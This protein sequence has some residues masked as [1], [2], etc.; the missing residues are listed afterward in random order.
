M[1]N[2]QALNRLIEYA[3]CVG[4][5]TD[6]SLSAERFIV[7][8]CDL[9]DGT[10]TIDFGEND[11]KKNIADIFGMM[12][13]DIAKLKAHMLD[14]INAENEVSFSDTVYAQKKLL[15]AK[16]Q[17]R[18]DKCTVLMPEVLLKCMLTDPSDAIK[19][20]LISDD[21]AIG[22]GLLDKKRSLQ[23][24]LDRLYG[25]LP[26]D[27]GSN[28]PDK[29][30]KPEKPLMEDVTE[31]DR[32]KTVAE[33]VKNVK[34]A[35]ECLLSEI[36]GQD[37]AV[38][39]F[40]TGYFQAELLSLTDKKRVR[41]R[42]MFLF[43]GPPG[44]GKTF[45]AEKAAEVLGL[46]FMRFDMSEY[47][48]HEANIE[49][50]GSDK[51]YKNGKE[52]NVT[53]FVEKNPKCILLFDEIEKA[54]ICVIHLFL[55][56]LDAGRLRDNFTDTE[57]SFTDAII[58]FTTNAGKQLYEQ[59]ESGDFS[60][61][62]KKVILKA[63]KSDVNPET[64]NPFFPAAICSRFA[65]GNVVMFN[66]I[67]AHNLREIAKRE[68]LRHAGNFEKEIGIS[69]DI[70][71]D[72]YTALLF[73]EGG[74]ADARMIRS[75]SE[76]FFD[77]ELFELFRLV[78]SDK[79]ANG[80]EDIENI[81]IGVQLP[82]NDKNIVSLF[83]PNEAAD[84]LVFS[85]QS[86]ADMCGRS[87]NGCRIFDAQSVDDAVKLLRNNDIRLVLIDIA[88]GRTGSEY[89]N[90]EDMASVS[91][92]FFRYIRENYADMPVY[93][94]QTEQT[95]LNAEEKI[96]F[97]RTG[98][99]GVIELTADM[100]QFTDTL[101]TVCS[102][103]HRQ[104]SMAYLAKANKIISFETAQKVSEDGKTAEIQL[105]D[106]KMSTAVEAEDSKNIL[107]NVSKPNVRFEDVIGAEDAKKELK[108]FVDYL[109]NPKK[110]LGTGVRAPKGVI[111]YGP[112]G[113]GK[114]MLA[115]AMACE[116]DVT[117]ITAEGN[118]FLQKLV[119][120]G[121]ERVHELFRTAR[122]YAPA[123]LFV[124]E[125]D[126]IARERRGGEASTVSGEDV[127]TA[128]LTEMDGFKND[129]TKP[130]FVLAAT[131]FDVR[132]GREKSLD[133]AL[134]RRFDRRV[135]IDLPNKEE[136]IRYI[137]L[138]TSANEAYALSEAEIGNIAVRSTGMSLADIESAMELA[139]RSALRDGGF[140]VTD[141][142][143]EEAFETFNSGD[144]KKW[145]STLLERV[146][147]HEAGHA[148]VC[149]HGGE[150]PSYVT[151]VAR[152]NHGGY[153]Q[154][155][156]NEG[157]AICTKEE[158]LARIR[159][160]LG[161]RAAE[162]VYYG[163]TDGISTGASGDLDSATFFASQIICTYGMDSDFGLAV[164]DSEAAKMGETSSEVRHAVN[165]ILDEQMKKTVA[166]VAV[167]KAAID[168][169]VKELISKNHLTGKE[170]EE[171]FS[172]YF[173]RG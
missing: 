101:S 99:R 26:E 153:M 41:P 89:L 6:V 148:F 16:I 17:A 84:I 57:V 81:R 124:D 116:S 142:I 46:P 122:K 129:S 50:C 108:Y 167:G 73:A 37:N 66:H 44:V 18:H 131:N 69:V 60:G 53:G 82:E 36:Y 67:G 74:A 165:K 107:S 80:I 91:R 21:D 158:L 111:L 121:K 160:S 102:D 110:Y 10:L 152:G 100:A 28:E 59:S 27:K 63:L 134:M 77:D 30:Q 22:Q 136:R 42:A 112:P 3:Q 115:K 47:S 157:K 64:G 169:L 9:L 126:A 154:H 12:G 70:D 141:A 65:S 120:E 8:V 151:V 4:N 90:A 144:V 86:V 145:D 97:M 98:A 103:I 118:Q 20:G 143:M 45:L 161:G 88:Y 130:V 119:G 114:T 13:V 127:L 43:A 32:K 137:K 139:L 166:T 31:G 23:Q 71:E 78:A 79:A 106:F 40:T 19:K 133:P 104:N 51:V 85:S 168:A 38:S 172:K 138:K 55:Q 1:E 25:E 68:V 135:Y 29:P 140:K 39:V 54:H 61:L 170:I 14:Y 105:F 96:S 117:F 11:S 34:N 52:G 56:M 156:D 2:S 128:F 72:V 155:G 159:T 149:W 162:I 5:R 58:I 33:L 7:A 150:T 94:L 125:I 76:T 109:K 113:T 132:P 83:A 147:R 15:E 87:H 92:D 146:A 95:V 163:E 48:D 171:I 164:I 62:S 123:I 173:D 24:Q 35:R 75:R 49:F 93:L